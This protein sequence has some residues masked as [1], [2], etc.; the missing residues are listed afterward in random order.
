VCS[1]GSNT[2]SRACNRIKPS[3]IDT[4][5]Y[6]HLYYAFASI[7][8]TTFQVQPADSQD[9]PVYSEFTALKSKGVHT[10]IAVGGFDFSDPDKATHYTWSQLVA[11]A[12]NRAAFISS[13][14]SF[15]SQY[16]FEGEPCI[17]SGSV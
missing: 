10:W 3:D 13:L 8:P 7:D 5:K 2:Y 1:Q 11:S 15:M 16:G 17:C 6:T 9:I 12:S 4:S 14:L